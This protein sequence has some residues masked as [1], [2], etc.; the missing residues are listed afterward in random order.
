M[1]F[2]PMPYLA[3]GGRASPTQ[4]KFWN[5]CVLRVAKN[6]KLTFLGPK[7]QCHQV[8]SGLNK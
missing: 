1:A 6:A 4:A 3:H 8:H 7:T 2:E 5:S